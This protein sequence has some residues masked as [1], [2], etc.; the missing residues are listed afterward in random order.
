MISGTFFLL[1]LPL[2][3][4]IPRDLTN[5]CGT[6]EQHGLPAAGGCSC[7]SCLA[8]PLELGARGELQSWMLCSGIA[9]K[10]TA[11][12]GEQGAAVGRRG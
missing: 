9:G 7:S 8:F 11:G 4:S 5:L 1:L 2:I 6:G 10:A 3:N 12:G